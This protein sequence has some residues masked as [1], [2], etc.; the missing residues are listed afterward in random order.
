MKRL[1]RKY[2][3]LLS[4]I[5]IQVFIKSKTY[6]DKFISKIILSIEDNPLQELLYGKIKSK[7]Y[8]GILDGKV[9]L[10]AFFALVSNS[11]LSIYENT[12][13]VKVLALLK[14]KLFLNTIKGII[15]SKNILSF[16]NFNF[17][18][19]SKFFLKIK[20]LIF[21]KGNL[22]LSIAE[23]NILKTFNKVKI[24]YKNKL[25]NIRGFNR[26]IF[27]IT[28]IKFQNLIKTS[29]NKVLNFNY[30]LINF[31]QQ[32]QPNFSNNID[33]KE[34]KSINL[35]SRLLLKNNNISINANKILIFIKKIVLASNN[36]RKNKS[37][38]KVNAIWSV[39]TTVKKIV[40]IKSDNGL[41]FIPRIRN[42]VSTFDKKIS[43]IKTNFIEK[44]SLITNSNIKTKILNKIYSIHYITLKIESQAITSFKKLVFIYQV[45]IRIFFSNKKN[46]AK[47][48][49]NF[50]YKLILAKARVQNMA[51]TVSSL[52]YKLILTKARVQNIAK[53][54][55]FL[56]YNIYLKNLLQDINF[57]I[58]Q[59]ALN[60]KT[61]ISIFIHKVK[62]I[63]NNL[64]FQYLKS[65]ISIFIFKIDQK[66]K[67]K[68]SSQLFPFVKIELTKSK[69]SNLVQNIFSFKSLAYIKSIFENSLFLKLN[70]NL[71]SRLSLILKFD[72]FE[73]IARQ[74][75]EVKS[76]VDIF[77][78][79][80]DN[81]VLN[82]TNF[83]SK[84]SL[85]IWEYPK[86]I[87]NGLIITQ[88]NAAIKE[89]GEL[90]II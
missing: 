14:S 54:I 32:V 35:N 68:Y 80:S 8:L 58:K 72:E 66:L 45:A 27:N 10:K 4:Q 33:I 77:I 2:Y 75:S 26:Q 19:I 84:I 31:L 29:N 83:N 43:I 3:F 86:Q 39:F 85:S 78:I 12:L 87:D 55:L 51:K 88:A 62:I 41:N 61:N 71:K 15:V 79:D 1:L 23:K 37:F 42:I 76:L 34:K 46:I 65:Q 21:L 59:T 7:V 47:L 74:I 24:E 69:F 81:K 44:L 5:L 64:I 48:T 22:H 52:K 57:K 53:T 20:Q 6:L 56:K 17:L 90:T 40:K 28:K 50:K 73:F 13:K 63:N 25:E 16:T 36:E 70:L 82:T 9:K 49:Q 30:K 67:I 60:F 18:S 89:N 38:Q 11:L